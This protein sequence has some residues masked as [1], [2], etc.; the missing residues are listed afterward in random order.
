MKLVAFSTTLVYLTACTRTLAKNLPRDDPYA[1]ITTTIT[2]LPVPTS[3]ASN[4][5]TDYENAVQACGPDI[6]AALQKLLPEFGPATG[7]TQN[8]TVTDPTFL[9]W[10][11]TQPTYETASLSCQSAQNALFADEASDGG[12]SSASASP[13][14]SSASAGPP[15]SAGS[16][17]AV[18]S[19]ASSTPTSAT[20]SS[21]SVSP[22]ASKPGGAISHEPEALL[23]ILTLIASLA[24]EL[25][26]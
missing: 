10:A 14:A 19:T 25:R 2:G 20:S 24:W 21:P 13:T 12:S 1:S 17:S 6:D 3:T 9:S 23:L 8:V 11:T 16:G 26:H 22:T 15:S 5:V 18:S 7:S 4:I